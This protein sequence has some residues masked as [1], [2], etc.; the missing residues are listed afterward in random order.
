M[1][2]EKIGCYEISKII[3]KGEDVYIVDN[4]DVKKLK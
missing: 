3:E 4:G 1:I 2:I